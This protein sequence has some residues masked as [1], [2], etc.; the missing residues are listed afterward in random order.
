MNLRTQLHAVSRHNHHWHYVYKRRLRWHGVSTKQII[1]SQLF[2]VVA[3]VYAGL[4]FDIQKESIVLLV[5]AL[6]LLPGIIDLSA[7]LTGVMCAKINHQI[8]A[9]KAS[10]WF[11]ISHAMVYAMIVGLC[12]GLLV[13]VVG[14]ALG[15]WLFGASFEKMVLL[16]ITSLLI[17]GLI[18]YPVMA[19]FTLLVRKLNMNPDNISG[20]VE[21]SVVDIVAIIVIAF[22]AGWLL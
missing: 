1:A 15:M 12:G 20:P 18:C 16:S 6:M 22:V 5:G 9:V 19:L 8:D 21:S 10:T 14:G 13:G 17:I 3:S 4:L 2:T 7:T 11:V